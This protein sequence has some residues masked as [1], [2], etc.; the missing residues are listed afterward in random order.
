M[1]KLVVQE[2]EQQVSK[3]SDNMKK[4]KNYEQL[5]IISFTLDVAYLT[6]IDAPLLQ[7][8]NLYKSREDRYH[9]KIRALE[10]LATGTTEEN[11]V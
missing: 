10:T 2:I 6:L 4:V 8:S 9:S 11:E 1:L 3:Q 5:N 7:Q